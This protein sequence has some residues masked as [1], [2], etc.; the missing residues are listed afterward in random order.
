M[1]FLHIVLY[2]FPKMLTRMNLFNNQ[3]LLDLV[4]I[5]FILVTLM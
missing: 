1:H 4:I 5:S 3:K 2:T